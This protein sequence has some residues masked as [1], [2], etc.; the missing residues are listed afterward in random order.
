[1]NWIPS[2]LASIQKGY[3]MAERLFSHRALGWGLLMDGCD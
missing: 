2:G 3:E 1:M